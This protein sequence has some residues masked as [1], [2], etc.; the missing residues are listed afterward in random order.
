MGETTDPNQ[1]NPPTGDESIR[2]G[3]DATR[4]QADQSGDIPE[5]ADPGQTRADAGED[6]ELA[7]LRE[8]LLRTRAEMDNVEK[9]AQREIDKARRFA[10]ERMISDLLP[11]LDSLDQAL[12]HAGEAE[13]DAGSVL[14]GTRL[15]RK[16]LVRVMEQHGV[17]IL[18][19]EGESFDPSWH[20]AMTT[21]PS[22]E[23]PPQTVLQVLQKG[24][25]LNERLLRPARVIVSAAATD[26]GSDGAD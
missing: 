25:K 4:E 1:D 26:D 11:V 15:T 12:D 10:L 13:G 19:P 17:E 14:E 6:T 16:M 24:F 22:A 18:D 9:R 23:H 2:S 8:A 3:Q 7:R 21:Q 5:D 20:E